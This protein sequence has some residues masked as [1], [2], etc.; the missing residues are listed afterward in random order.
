MT[1]TQL[2]WMLLIVLVALAGLTLAM[3][4]DSSKPNFEIMPD[5]AHSVPYDSF[6]PN[7]NFYDGKTL[8]PPIPGT[9]ARGEQPLYYNATPEDAIRAGEELHNPCSATDEAALARGAKVFAVYC[10]PCHGGAGRGDGLVAQRGFPPPPSFHADRALTMKDGQMFHVVTY[11]FGN[12]PS[13]AAQ[14]SREDRWKA[15]LHIRD[16]QRKEAA[17]AQSQAAA[18]AVPAEPVAPA[19]SAEPAAPPVPSAPAVPAAPATG[20][21]EIPAPVQPAPVEP[22]VTAPGVSQ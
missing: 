9:I 10:A 5:M 20:T 19:A 17:A 22:N 11:G 13:Y 4:R 18:P 7:P 12:M 16:L 3:E 8:Q 1:R 6:A 14:V 21:I 15:I 2:N